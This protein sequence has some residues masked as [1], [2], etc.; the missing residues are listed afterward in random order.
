MCVFPLFSTCFSSLLLILEVWVFDTSSNSLILGTHYQVFHK[1]NSVLILS[2][3]RAH[4]LKA[5][6]LETAPTLEVSS[7]SRLGFPA[8]PVVKNPPVNVLQSLVGE[9]PACLG[10]TKPVY[11]NY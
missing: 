8:G 1:S 11:P 4:W 9:D 10:A 2:H 7:K 6:S 5:Q 3:V